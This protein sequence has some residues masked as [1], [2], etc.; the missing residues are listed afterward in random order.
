VTGEISTMASTS[1]FSAFANA[2]IDFEVPTGTQTTDRYGNPVIE[3]EIVTIT[4]LLKPAQGRSFNR[5][6]IEYLY[7]GGIERRGVLLE[8]YLVHPTKYPDNFDSYPVGRIT[9][10]T[11]AGKTETGLFEVI[12]TVQNPYVQAVG[13]DLINRIQGFYRFEKFL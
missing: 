9:I 10:E 2:T 4:A 3:S 6:D 1:P 7:N 5:S 13:V 11:I 12:P 8:G